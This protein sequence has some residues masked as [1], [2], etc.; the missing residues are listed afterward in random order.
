MYELLI[1]LFI[2]ALSLFIIILPAFL[3]YAIPVRIVISI[4]RDDE[5]DDST[6]TASW[7]IA[8]IRV[9]RI[10][11]AQKFSVL[12]AGRSIWSGTGS[13]TVQ[14]AKE[15]GSPGSSLS[16]VDII[17]TA[18]AVA[19]PA[20][21]LVLIIWQQSCIDAMRGRIRIGL[22]DPVSTGMLYGGYWASR[23]AM[24]AARI[25]IDLE[26]EFDRA[27]IEVD[28]TMNLRIRHPLLIVMQGLVIVRD[29]Q[30]RKSLTKFKP[31]GLGSAGT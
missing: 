15:P 21:R 20:G 29:P 4:A 16:G 9:F 7:A 22:G 8:G 11:R 12:V 28:V 2:A 5:R 17:R 24:N 18:L 31:T 10:G 3:L 23:F 30:I 6:I 27:V 1:P 13:D 19:G 26:P 25:F 14:Q